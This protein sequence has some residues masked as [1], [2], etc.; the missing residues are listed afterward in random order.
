M[1]RLSVVTPGALAEEGAAHGLDA[2]EL[3]RIPETDDHVASE[4]VIFRG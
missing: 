4:V 1:I 3:R 2:E